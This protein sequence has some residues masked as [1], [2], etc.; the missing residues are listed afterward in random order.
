MKVFLDKDLGVIVCA[1]GSLLAIA[2]HVVPAELTNN[3]F[4]FAAFPLEAESHVKIWATFVHV[5]VGTVLSSLAFLLHEIWANLEVMAEVALVSVPTLTQTL[6]FVARLDFAFVMRVRT[7]VRK[8][9]LPV[10]EFLADS[11]GGELVVVGGCRS[12]LEIR[13]VVGGIVGT[14]V[15][16]NVVLRVHL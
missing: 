10:D 13:G 8:S 14:R 12:G 16:W 4:E 6:E 1:L 9:A 11:V 7:V 15:G 3:M 5:A 2:I